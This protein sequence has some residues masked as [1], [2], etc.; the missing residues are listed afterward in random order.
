[1]NNNLPQNNYSNRNFTAN[2]PSRYE[3]RAVIDITKLNKQ[4]FVVN[5]EKVIKHHQST[6]IDFR[7]KYKGISSN[8]LRNLLDLLNNLRERLRTERVSELTS[9]MISQVQYIKLRFI[10]AAGRDND[11]KGVRDFIIESDLI[12]CIDSIGRSVEQFQLICNYLEA[13]VA[14]HKYYIKG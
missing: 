3:A 7:K 11:G 9:N 14:Y 1:M 5:A 2:S 10:Y 12:N 6:H 8:Q 13:L 4:N